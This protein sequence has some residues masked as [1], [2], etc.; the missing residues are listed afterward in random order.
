MESNNINSN[1]TK[2]TRTVSANGLI[3]PVVGQGCWN[4]GD[5]PKKSADE[6]ASLRLGVSLGMNMIDTAEMYGDGAS[7]ELVGRAM[8]GVPR[9]EYMI[10]TKVLPHN[11]GKRGILKSCDASLRRLRTD[12]IDLYLLHWRGDITL[13][14]TVFCMEELF[15]A[16]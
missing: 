2:L 4:I 16:G 10:C 8:R 11:A 9:S 12:Y 15:R 1:N 6:E 7:E 3:L 13:E 14:E 5:D